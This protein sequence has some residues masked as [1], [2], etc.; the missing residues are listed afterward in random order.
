MKHRSH[1]GRKSTKRSGKR[2]TRRSAKR[3]R[4]HRKMSTRNAM[5]VGKGSSDKASRMLGTHVTHVPFSHKLKKFFGVG[6]H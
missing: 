6:K 5:M 3:R 1:R 4:S 2:S